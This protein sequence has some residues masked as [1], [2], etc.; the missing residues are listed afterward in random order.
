MGFWFIFPPTPVYQLQFSFPFPTLPIFV[1]NPIKFSKSTYHSLPRKI[2]ASRN[3]WLKRRLST[4]TNCTLRFNFK[5]TVWITAWI[6][7]FTAHLV[8]VRPRFNCTTALFL[9]AAVRLPVLHHCS[10]SYCFHGTH[11]DPHRGAIL[12]DQWDG[13]FIGRIWSWMRDNMAQCKY[14]RG[15]EG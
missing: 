14:L 1:S 9:S 7:H 4:C 8:G 10:C 15:R 5:H 2:L 12:L 6:M 11:L 13:T 3:S